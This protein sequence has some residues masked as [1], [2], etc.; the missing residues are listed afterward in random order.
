MIWMVKMT[1]GVQ[2]AREFGQRMRVALW[3]SAPNLTSRILRPP[4]TDEERQDVHQV[5]PFGVQEDWSWA[6]AE[7]R[8]ERAYEEGGLPLWAQAALREVEAEA[9]V[10][11]AKREKEITETHQKQATT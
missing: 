1:L 9:R 3:S 6:Q 8:M 4:Q 2:D 11:R 7:K 10:E 5:T